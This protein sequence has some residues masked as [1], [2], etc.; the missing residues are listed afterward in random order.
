MHHLFGSP[1]LNQ[2]QVAEWMDKN[3]IETPKAPLQGLSKVVTFLTLVTLPFAAIAQ[4]SLIKEQIVDIR[5][6]P[7]QPGVNVI[8][9]FTNDGRSGMITLA[10]R[11][12]AN[13]HG[14]DVFLVMTETEPGRRDWNVV[15]G[16]QGHITADAPFDGEHVLRAVRF[17]R[18]FVDA[19]T[20]TLMLLSSR[21][22]PSPLTS[23]ARVN[24]EF[25]RLV[26]NPEGDPTTFDYFTPIGGFVTEMRYCNAEMAIQTE[27]GIPVRSSYQGADTEDG[28]FE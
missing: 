4:D 26:P 28:C 18:A 5:P 25:H 15:N 2:R 23:P 11:D 27:L 24:I 10:W 21:L 13:A 16:P 20:A 17:A 8:P 7:L 22:N 1:I 12:N 9:D 6:I 14:Y 19:K 3:P